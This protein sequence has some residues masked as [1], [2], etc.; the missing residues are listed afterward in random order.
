M[1]QITLSAY[2]FQQLLVFLEAQAG[3]LGSSASLKTI[4]SAKTLK[5][6]C[7]AEGEDTDTRERD[8]E[9]NAWQGMTSRCYNPR[10]KY[11]QF[12]GAQGVKVCPRWKDSFEHFY[13]DMGTRPPKMF[14][15]RINLSKDFSRKNCRWATASE[16]RLN[17]YK[18]IVSVVSKP[19]KHLSKN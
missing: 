11:F 3:P 16:Q 6:H 10:T 8:R 14:L 4:R 5:I 17:R 1:S 15:E 2:D 12:Y 18:Q 13:A 9:Y 7:H 19:V